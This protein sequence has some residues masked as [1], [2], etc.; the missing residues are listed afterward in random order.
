MTYNIRYDNPGDGIH[1]WDK[2][3]DDLLAYVLSERPGVF[4]IQEGLH[5]QVGFL[6]EGQA[7]FDVRGVGRDDGTT[8][9]E[10]SAVFFDTLRFSP[11]RHGTFWLS[12][13]PDT[14]SVGWDAALPRIV[15]WVH[16]R[17]G[18]TDRN[19]VVFNTHFDHRGTVAREQSAHLLRMKVREIAGTTPAIVTGDFNA[20]ETER[21]YQVLLSP[22]GS[23]P[24]L[25]DTRSISRMP[26][27]GPSTTFTGFEISEAGAAN[28]IDY[29][30]VSEGVHVQNHRTIPA[31]R[32]SGYLSDHLPVVADILLP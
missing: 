2:R 5:H 22:E 6:K 4:C 18:A 12:P 30:F 28:R 17:D 29:I 24:R 3:K 10:Y 27:Q 16:L 9:G 19:F 13:S 21:P 14:P 15:T 32:S 31:R 20:E 26:P 1:A 11:L 23:S 7:G 25:V 8:K